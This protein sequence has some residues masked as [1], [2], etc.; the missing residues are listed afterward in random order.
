MRVLGLAGQV[1]PWRLVAAAAIASL[2]AACGGLPTSLPIPR[3]TAGTQK[4]AEDEQLMLA[5][6]QRLFNLL[7]TTQRDGQTVLTTRI[8]NSA[9]TDGHRIG[10]RDFAQGKVSP[11]QA[12]L[13]FTWHFTDPLTSTDA[14]GTIRLDHIGV[15]G[16]QVSGARLE[17]VELHF[18]Y[19]ASAQVEAGGQND[20]DWENNPQHTVQV[21]T[22]SDP[23]GGV[24][25]SQRASTGA[26]HMPVVPLGRAIRSKMTMH[27]DLSVTQASGTIVRIG[28][29]SP[30]HVR[31]NL[32]RSSQSRSPENVD[33]DSPTAPVLWTAGDSDDTTKDYRGP[34]TYVNQHVAMGNGTVPATVVVNADERSGTIFGSQPG[35]IAGVEAVS[36]TFVC[37]PPSVETTLPSYS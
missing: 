10:P 25:T 24:A 1:V 19:A 31:C 7:N 16:G 30:S 11:A 21:Y 27:E 18:G 9:T 35:P 14:T 8:T 15:Y 23:N 5:T 29:V 33:V 12:T 2:M 13:E 4:P 20:G 17:T 22:R 32:I 26:I 34:G 37:P 28:S 6:M 3:P 36:G